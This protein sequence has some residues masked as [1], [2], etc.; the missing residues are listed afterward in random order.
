MAKAH[1]QKCPVAAMLNI[2][3]DHWTWLVIREAFYGASRF[4]EFERNT[5]IAKNLLADRLASLVAAQIFQK[6]DIGEKGPR[7]AYELTERG[8]A[9]LPILTAMTQWGNDYL[10]EA[11]AQP[12]EIIDNQAE[13]P[14]RVVNVT[15]QDG[16]VLG[17]GDIIVK[18]GPGASRAARQRFAQFPSA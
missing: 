13:K 12:I 17:R 7:Y 8:E 1:K 14:V 5:G 15:S 18:A 2:V 9:L 16:R 10:Y 4:S 6:R 11:G 3:G